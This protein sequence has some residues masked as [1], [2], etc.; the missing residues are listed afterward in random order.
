MYR[1]DKSMHVLLFIGE[2]FQTV[3]AADIASIYD[4]SNY[5]SPPIRQVIITCHTYSWP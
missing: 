3:K 4:I 5:V 1:A 2:Q